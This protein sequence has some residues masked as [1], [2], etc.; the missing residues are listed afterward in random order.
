MSFSEAKQYL[1]KQEIITYQD[2]RKFSSSG[3]RP[4]NLPSQPE[5]KYKDQ[6]KGW[7]DFLGNE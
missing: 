6:W 7:K 1:K 4:I 3:K 2:W 5:V